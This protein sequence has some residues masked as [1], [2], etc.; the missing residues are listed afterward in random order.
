[1]TIS[2]RGV[3][4]RRSQS[5]RQLFHGCVGEKGRD[6]VYDGRPSPTPA[7]EGFWLRALPA[8]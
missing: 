4:Q 6:P 7:V 5:R 3:E 2:H 8:Q 1:M